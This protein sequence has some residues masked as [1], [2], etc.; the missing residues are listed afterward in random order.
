V[1]EERERKWG[2]LPG[3][4]TDIRAC[5]FVLGGLCVGGLCFGV[6]GGT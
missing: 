2:L 4:Q 5:G 6:V 1:K 3:L